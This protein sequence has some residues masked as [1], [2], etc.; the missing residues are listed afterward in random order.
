MTTRRLIRSGSRFEELAAYSRAVVEDP[1]V[2]VS[3]TAGYD[4]RTGTIPDDPGEQTEQCL[5]T[6]QAALEEAG[7]SLADVVRVRC[8]L[9]DRAYVEPMAA[10]LRKYFHDVRPTNTTIVCQFATEEMKVEIEVTALKRA[11]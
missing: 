11:G 9:A 5:R 1:W 7:A 6:I 3:G 4:F 8:Y 2:F 10:V